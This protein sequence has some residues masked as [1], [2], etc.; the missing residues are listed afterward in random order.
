MRHGAPPCEREGGVQEPRAAAHVQIRAKDAGVGAGVRETARSVQLR[1]GRHDARRGI[2]L[3]GQ[4]REGVQDVPVYP[5]L[6]LRLLRVQLRR[7]RRSA[8][9]RSQG[10]LIVL[11]LALY[12]AF[13]PS[14]TVPRK[15]VRCVMSLETRRAHGSARARHRPTSP[16]RT[17]PKAA[18]GCMYVPALREKHQEN[19]LQ[20]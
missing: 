11:E 6:R 2:R 17:R 14:D 19:Y 3:R 8:P 4:I 5:R 15:H 9:I 13:R 10:L 20:Y 16:P 7:T 1:G 12:M 18:A